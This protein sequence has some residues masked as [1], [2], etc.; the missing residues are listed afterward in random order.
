MGN[1]S[2]YHEEEDRLLQRYFTDKCCGGQGR[3][4]PRYQE[5]VDDCPYQP[6]CAG[7]QLISWPAYACPTLDTRTH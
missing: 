6:R 4:R 1:V 2:K 7:S 3:E 5:R